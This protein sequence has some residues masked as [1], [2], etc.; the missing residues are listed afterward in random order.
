MWNVVTQVVS[1]LKTECN[2][3]DET[4]ELDV[5]FTLARINK[6]SV[7]KQEIK[8]KTWKCQV[9][10]VWMIYLIKDDVQ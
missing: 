8:T 2:F 1:D 10:V 9:L 5:T 6:P 4:G 3:R 7:N